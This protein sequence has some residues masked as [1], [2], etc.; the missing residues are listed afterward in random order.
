M[1]TLPNSN[2][3]TYGAG[4]SSHFGKTARKAIYGTNV[5]TFRRTLKQS[6]KSNFYANCAKIRANRP[7]VQ[8]TT[9]TTLLGGTTLRMGLLSRSADSN[10]PNTVKKTRQ[11]VKMRPTDD[12]FPKLRPIQEKLSRFLAL[13]AHG[14]LAKGTHQPLPLLGIPDR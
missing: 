14:A 8:S 13:I 2:N 9:R 10:R 11:I 3:R 1:G 5:L 4:L 12:Q 6:Q 7:N